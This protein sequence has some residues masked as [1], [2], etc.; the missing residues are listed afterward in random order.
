VIEDNAQNFNDGPP[1]GDEMVS[2]ARETNALVLTQISK[3]T[4]DLSSVVRQFAAEPRTTHHEEQNNRDAPKRPSS[5]ASLY[6]G[7]GRRPVRNAFVALG[8]IAAA[9][10]LI[11]FVGTN[12]LGVGA[13]SQGGHNNPASTGTSTA[14]PARTLAPTQT[15][16]PTVTEPGPIVDSGPREG[17]SGVATLLPDGNIRYVMQ[18]GDVG[19][20]VCDRFG[21]ESYQ[22]FIANDE[23]QPIAAIGCQFFSFEGD[24]M[25]LTRDTPQE[26]CNRVGENFCPR[27]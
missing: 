16:T 8:G 6:R 25:V 7:K 15:P 10:V 14:G 12:L 26:S 2:F 27:T 4:D 22:G 21:R 24:I 1:T 19:G 3:Q 5:Q 20:V 13:W 23:N 11:I 18:A 17:A 9:V